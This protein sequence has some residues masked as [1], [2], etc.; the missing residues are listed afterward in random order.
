MPW[1][2]LALRPFA[3]VHSHLIVAR[4]PNP[5]LLASAPRPLDR[6][7]LETLA[8]TPSA[9]RTALPQLLQQYLERSGNVLDAQLPYEPHPSP[10]RRVSFSA[11]SGGCVR[12]IAHVVREGDRSK[13]TV[14]SGFAVD[15]SDGQSVLVTCAHTLEEI[16]WSPLLVL[17]K[18]PQASLLAA[19]PDL[20]D[21]RS[22][23][24]F[25]LSAIDSAFTAHPIASVLSSLHRSD[26][27][28]LSPFPM[29][30][31]LRSLPISPYPVPAGTPIRA[32]F[33]SETKPKEE[34]WQPWISCTWSK[35]VQGTVVGYRDFAGRE[36][37]PGTYDTL[38]HMLFR[39]L[40][41]T[42]S[43]GGPIVDEN[44]GAVVGVMLGTR[45]DSTIEGV[46]GW[47]VPAETIFEMF[48]LP[49]VN[50]SK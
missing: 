12:L 25:V 33:V 37:V 19:P 5:P 7:V 11:D 50:N 8:G 44:T 17:P 43:S 47:G 15:T 4:P 34:G 40:P 39:P 1:P 36:A 21:V 3:T 10:S 13:I 48:S 16:R 49:G 41:T 31:P 27:M 6:L 35:W 23:G 20:S 14:S 26:I 24:S 42:G 38:S 46:R 18:E 29:R 45:M 32:H 2:R 30:V 22:S 28:L 9:G